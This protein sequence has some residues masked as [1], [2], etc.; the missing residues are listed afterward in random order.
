MSE[1]SERWGQTMTFKSFA[2]M[3]AA[4]FLTASAASAASYSATSAFNDSYG[5]HGDGHS[6]Y[7]HGLSLDFE[8]DGLFTDSGSTASLSGTVSQNGGADGFFVDLS[9]NSFTTP[10]P[11]LELTSNA[12]ASNGGPVDPSTWSFWDLIEGGVSSIIG[13]GAFSGWDFDVISKPVSEIYAFQ[14]GD[15]ANGKNVGFGL[16]GWLF[17]DGR[18]AFADSVNPCAQPASGMGH[19]CDFNVDLA[20]VPL[21]ASALLL[22]GGFAALGGMRRMKQKAA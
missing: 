17:L 6:L 11:K 1:C 7:M 9:F 20:P 14:S 13:F 22:L 19:I 8:S 15:G 16:S 5:P 4:S 3:V 2:A 12:Y 18:T 21:P 10:D